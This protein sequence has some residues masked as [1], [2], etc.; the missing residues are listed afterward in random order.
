VVAFVSTMDI[1]G[2]ARQVAEIL[3]LPLHLA[4]V[5]RDPAQDEGRIAIGAN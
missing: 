5:R 2:Y 1:S 4:N 3:A